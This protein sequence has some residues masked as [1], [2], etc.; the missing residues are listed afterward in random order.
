MCPAATNLWVGV[1]L[2]VVNLT[3]QA[4]LDIVTAGGASVAAGGG[5]AAANITATAIV[6][7]FMGRIVSTFT[8][9]AGLQSIGRFVVDN[10]KSLLVIGGL[11]A[12]ATF[13]ARIYVL[14]TMGSMHNGVGIGPVFDNDVD[15]GTNQISNSMMCGQYYGRFLTNAE[16]AEQYSLD[17]KSVDA[18]NQNK[19]TYQRYFALSNP[20][21]MVA[22]LGYRTA[23]SLNHNFL[24][25]TLN[26][27]GKI[28]NPA[29]IAP[30][31]F[32]SVNSTA[33][34]AA[35]VDTANYGNVQCGWTQKEYATI[36]GKDSYK[37]V[38]ENEKVLS[39]SGRAQ[40]IEDKYGKCWTE[41]IGKILEDKDLYRDDNGDISTTRGDCSP[42]QLGVNNPTYGDL[43]FRY[44][45]FKNRM[46]TLDMYSEFSDVQPVTQQTPTGA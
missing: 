32:S 28:F 13:L 41:T 24:A 2:G 31:I 7:A 4:A 35:N 8:T 23:G 9:K 33:S 42:E 15:N 37:S 20:N 30:R 16:A 21:S 34:A 14:S 5:E 40:D 18:R 22:S 1:G 39:E 6:R 43:V 36:Q 29:T 10:G 17:R 46:N 25:N 45:I 26:S 3:L 38:L 44:R 27:F 11:T 19:S 12:G